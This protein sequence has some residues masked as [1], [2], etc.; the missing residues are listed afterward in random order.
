M[1][2]ADPAYR[3]KFFEDTVLGIG[4][5]EYKRFNE[6]QRN[7]LRDKLTRKALEAFQPGYDGEEFHG[8]IEAITLHDF[9]LWSKYGVPDR[10]VED[11]EVDELVFANVRQKLETDS[12]YGKVPELYYTDN[13]QTDHRL[14]RLIDY[15]V[16][17]REPHEKFS[18]D[19]YSLDETIGYTAEDVDWLVTQGVLDDLGGESWILTQ[20]YIDALLVSELRRRG[21]ELANERQKLNPA[22]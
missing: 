5:A 16:Q 21:D 11:W 1:K 17:M 20:P 12:E 2:D 7:E 6:T 22:E 14:G 3:P 13:D 9:Q 19:L 15:F 10:E 18:L 4:F 8:L